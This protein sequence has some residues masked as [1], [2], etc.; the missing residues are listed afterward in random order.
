[1]GRSIPENS[2]RAETRWGSGLWLQCRPRR[3]EV[4]FPLL[5]APRIMVAAW[6]IVARKEMQLETPGSHFQGPEALHRSCPPQPT[7]TPAQSRSDS[8]HS[9]VAG[10][11]GQGTRPEAFLVLQTLHAWLGLSSGPPQSLSRASES[12]L[13]PSKLA[14]MVRGGSE[15]SHAGFWCAEWK[16]CPSPMVRGKGG[17]TPSRAGPEDLSPPPPS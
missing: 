8:L 13:C 6:Y 3:E 12:L 17:T 4:V 9:Q 15:C 1:M 10:S 5:W 7:G 14:G 11:G 2:S 16:G